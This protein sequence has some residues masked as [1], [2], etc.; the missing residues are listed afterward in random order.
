MLYDVVFL[1]GLGCGLGTR[2]MAAAAGLELQSRRHGEIAAAA[3]RRS[4]R[5]RVAGAECSSVPR[6]CQ[7]I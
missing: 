5:H 4:L 1:M 2:G 6:S 3:R 7:S